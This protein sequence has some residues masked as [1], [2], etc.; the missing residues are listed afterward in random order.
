LS[1][2]PRFAAVAVQPQPERLER[3][4]VA[5]VR[6]V[7]DRGQTLSDLFGSLG[8]EPSEAA[9]I[10]D[11]ARPHLD[12][13]RVRPGLEVIAY[14]G[15]TSDLCQVELYV[16]RRGRLFLTS[17]SEGWSGE[18][19][20][21]ARD[22]SVVSVEGTV[23]TSLIGALT[24]R[25]AP[26]QVAY[27]MAEVLQW[28]VD[29]HRDLRTGDRFSVLYEEVRLD[30]RFDGVGEILAVQLV[31]RGRE[32]EAYRFGDGYYDRQGRPLEKM[33]LRSPLPFSRVT[34]KF[35][36]NRFHPVL[37]KNRPHY[38]VDYGAPRG[39]PVRVTAGGV[40]SF[41]GWNGGAGRMVKVRHPND[42][43]TAYLHLSGV[44]DGVRAGARVRQG[45]VVGYVGST[46]LATGPH[47]DYRVQHRG[48]WIDPLS[49][50]AVPAAPIES[51]RRVEYLALRDDYR[52]RL[53][54]E[55]AS[56]QAPDRETV[57]AEARPS[58]ADLSR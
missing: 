53:G 18:Y 36:P 2:A 6:T 41:A 4:A 49:L 3:P 22:V 20:E 26:A 39:T 27:E 57:L 31:N 28:D 14:S 58:S 35:S 8:V 23:T 47:L 55:G 38:G 48:R 44:A 21:L 32:V 52:N 9:A 7:L 43:L 12:P 19:R 51:A 5:P 56:D 13:R 29:F 45:Q 33:F 15:A 42:Y 30:G 10:V 37:K 54:L 17:G 40:V 34:S 46:G 24:E 25:G 16:P 50:K 1:P 11:A